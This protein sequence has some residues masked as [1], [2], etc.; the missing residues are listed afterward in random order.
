MRVKVEAPAFTFMHGRMPYWDRAY[1]DPG[2]TIWGPGPYLKLPYGDGAP[3]WEAVTRVFVPSRLRRC[4][5]WGLVREGNDWYWLTGCDIQ[6]E[7]ARAGERT[8]E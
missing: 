2:G 4:K 1:L 7:A 5:T 3:K 6:S 8:E